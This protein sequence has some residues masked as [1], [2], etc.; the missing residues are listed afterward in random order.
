LS[1]PHPISLCY[2][3]IYLVLFIVLTYYF[4]GLL[5]SRCT[6]KIRRRPSPADG[7]INSRRRQAA[8]LRYFHFHAL[9]IK[10]HYIHTGT[11]SY[12]R[13][14][15]PPFP[16]LYPFPLFTRHYPLIQ[17]QIPAAPV[18]PLLS[19]IIRPLLAVGF[20]VSLWAVEGVFAGW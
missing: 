6:V 15:L 8:W 20:E 13:H 5:N 14:F 10:R 18:T 17:I 7:Q 19:F 9:G 4:W 3:V 1:L 12:T 2:F 11:H 16:P